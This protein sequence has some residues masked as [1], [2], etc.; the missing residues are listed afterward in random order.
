MK[1]IMNFLK[2]NASN[3][4]ALILAVSIV[5]A[6]LLISGTLALSGAATNAP[7]AAGSQ[8]LSG[9]ASNFSALQVSDGSASAPGF[10]FTDD[11]DNGLYRIGSNNI[12]IAAGGTKIVDVGASGV[13]V[14]GTLAADTFSP[15]TYSS[16]DL[17][18]TTSVRGAA[19]VATNTLSIGGGFG[20]TGCS[21]SAAG[22]L[23][24]NGAATI[25]GAATITGQLDAIAAVTVGGGYGATGCTLSAAGVLQCNGA[26]TFDGATTST[27]ALAANAGITVDSTAFTV[28]DTSGN[29]ATAGTLSFGGNASGPAEGNVVINTYNRV[30]AAEIDAG[31]TIVT[32]PATDAFRLVNVVATAYG[33]GTCGGVTT[34]D[35]ATTT[36][37]T[38]TSYTA[39]N[40]TQST[41]LLINA[42]G[43]AVLADNA[44]FVVQS[45]GVDI[46]VKGIGSNVTTCTGVDVVVSYVLQ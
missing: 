26:A 33:G 46:R 17:V 42:V 4:V 38:L 16:A 35:F 43:V 8:A 22:V 32:V 3:F 30:T 27:G 15:A 41:P 24:C 19:I 37:V 6:A 10:S 34:V 11:T 45:D 21:F 28:A 40:L 39:A 12:G 31:K 23:E 20:D 14:V 2:G 5:G 1:S 13:T 18:G 9:R 44:S 29:V 25:G 36:G 7:V